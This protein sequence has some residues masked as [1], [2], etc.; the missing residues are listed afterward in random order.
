[1]ILGDVKNGQVHVTQM[2]APEE[3][4]QF[5][6]RAGCFVKGVAKIRAPLSRKACKK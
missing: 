5:H 6:F 1:M 4:E 2:R 3:G